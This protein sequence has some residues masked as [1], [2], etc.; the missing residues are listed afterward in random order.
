MS[1]QDLVQYIANSNPNTLVNDLHRDLATLSPEERLTQFIQLFSLV[2]EL[3]DR[4][5]QSVNLAWNYFV[6]EQL[7]RASFPTLG[8]FQEFINYDSTVLPVIDRAEVNARRAGNSRRSLINRWGGAI[9]TL[10]PEDIR[11]PAY[12]RHLLAQL[13][14]LSRACT[15]DQA[16]PLLRE[17]SRLRRSATSRD[18]VEARPYEAN[19]P[20]LGSYEA[21]RLFTGIGTSDSTRGMLAQGRGEARRSEIS[22]RRGDFWLLRIASPHLASWESENV[23][24][25]LMF[26]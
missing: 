19:R 18:A 4:L 6:E 17:Q 26:R 9:E 25:K 15:I 23:T 10:L 24:Y 20:R 7:W 14:R 3:G 11:P 12:S 8:A 21:I 2:S 16:I 5:D 22:P 13:V 1:E